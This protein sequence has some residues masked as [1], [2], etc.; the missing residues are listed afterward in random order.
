[1]RLGY[2]RFQK[3]GAVYILTDDAKQTI[4]HVTGFR[5]V[6]LF[7]FAWETEQTLRAVEELCVQEPEGALSRKILKKLDDLKKLKGTGR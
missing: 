7:Q 5:H 6:R 3:S 2:C 1:V 4:A